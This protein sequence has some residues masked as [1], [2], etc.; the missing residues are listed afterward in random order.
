MI[1]TSIVFFFFKFSLKIQDLLWVSV[2][3]VNY[4]ICLFLRS[5]NIKQYFGPVDGLQ[6]QAR[7]DASSHSLVRTDIWRILMVRKR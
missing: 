6:S 2:S 1:R 5:T 3:Q 7:P 4:G